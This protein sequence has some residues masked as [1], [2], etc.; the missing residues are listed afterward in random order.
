[1]RLQVELIPPVRSLP[2]RSTMTLIEE[3]LAD[4]IALDTAFLRGSIPE[5]I[6]LLAQKAAKEVELAKRNT[7]AG[8]EVGC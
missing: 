1:M 7:D 8:K 4:S 2:A 6:E 5:A 3:V